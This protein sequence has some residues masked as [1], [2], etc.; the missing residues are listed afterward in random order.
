[1]ITNPKN[2][3]HNKFKNINKIAFIT[4]T[5]IFNIFNNYKSLTPLVNLFSKRTF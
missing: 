1:M 3:M 4:G 2:N 5:N